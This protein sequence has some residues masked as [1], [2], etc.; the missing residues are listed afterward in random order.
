M[1]LKTAVQVEGLAGKKHPPVRPGSPTPSAPGEDEPGVLSDGLAPLL[2][3]PLCLLC[4]STQ[5]NALAW[6]EVFLG[7]WHSQ[8]LSPRQNQP[9]LW[10]YKNKSISKK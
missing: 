10:T 1:A 3:C 8:G 2:T 5:D 9:K 6:S 4:P 7:A